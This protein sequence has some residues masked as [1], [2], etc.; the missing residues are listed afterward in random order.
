MSYIRA[1]GQKEI[2]RE[3]FDCDRD[4]DL[5]FVLIVIQLAASHNTIGAR[6]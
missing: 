3:R 2:V 5:E 4:R 6:L 1:V